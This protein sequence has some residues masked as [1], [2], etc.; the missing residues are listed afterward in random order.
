MFL[1]VSIDGEDANT[2]K[3]AAQ[4]LLKITGLPTNVGSEVDKNTCMC[5]C[6]FDKII[7]KC[8]KSNLFNVPRY[9]QI[10]IDIALPEFLY[11]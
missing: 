5:F 10:H 6:I 11:S 8:L 9:I 1:R 2:K 3:D 4:Q 7:Y